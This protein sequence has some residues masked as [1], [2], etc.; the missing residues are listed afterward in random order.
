MDG[1][2]TTP[3]LFYRAQECGRQRNEIVDPDDESTITCDPG[4]STAATN[5]GYQRLHQVVSEYRTK[6]ERGGR[7][8]VLDAFENPR[9][10]G[11]DLN[12][13]WGWR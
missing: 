9:R 8:S 1:T 10:W 2:T 11:A 13:R 5:D 6:A 12:R 3:H 7:R 4:L